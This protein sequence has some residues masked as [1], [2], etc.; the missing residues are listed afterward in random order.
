MAV[1]AAYMLL[2]FPDL[3]GVSG[4]PYVTAK[5]EEATS[6]VDATA[7]GTRRDLGIAYLTAH[8]ILAQASAQSTSLSGSTLVTTGPVNSE[9]VG[10]LSR[11]YGTGGSSSSSGSAQTSYESTIYGKEYA[12]LLRTLATTP[13]IW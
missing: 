10:D 8:L 6:Q 2:H 3:P 11:S 1:D 5:I 4:V 13:V 9:R 7:W 12:R